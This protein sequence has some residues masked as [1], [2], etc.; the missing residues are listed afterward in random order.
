MVAGLLVGLFAWY[1]SGRFITTFEFGVAGLAAGVIIYVIQLKRYGDTKYTITN[2]ELVRKRGDRVTR[3]IPIKNIEYYYF[4]DPETFPRVKVQS[5]KDFS[6][7]MTKG[8]DKEI[9]AALEIV[10]IKPKIRMNQKHK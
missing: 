6:F 4:S 7:P 1:L 3:S 9:V 10:G 2:S 8:V 5:E